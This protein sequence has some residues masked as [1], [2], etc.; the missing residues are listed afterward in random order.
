MLFEHIFIFLTVNIYFKK[1]QQD[2]SMKMVNTQVAHT[3]TKLN[4]K[5]VQIIK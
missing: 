3:D 1:Y 2:S 4:L 5:H